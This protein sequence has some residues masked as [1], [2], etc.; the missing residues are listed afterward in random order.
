M[1][2]MFVDIL[3]KL[4]SEQGKEALLNPSKC[5][6]LLADYTK[7]DYKKESRL[8]LQAI[9]AGVQKVINTTGELELCKRQQA[10][11]LHE[12]YGIDQEISADIVD[13]LAF[14]LREKKECETPQSTF[15]TNCGKE[16]QKEW[17]V[18]PYCGTAVK[19]QQNSLKAEAPPLPSPVPAAQTAYPLPTA[20]EKKK[21]TVRNAALVIAGIILIIVLITVLS[22]EVSNSGQIAVPTTEN[23]NSK[24]A[25]QPG[26]GQHPNWKVATNTIGNHKIAFGNNRFVAGGYEGKAAY[27]SDGITWTAIENSIY[28]DRETDIDIYDITFGNNCF[29]AVGG[30][31]HRGMSRMAYSSDGIEWKAVANTTFGGN[32]VLAVTFG[33]NR[34]VAVGYGGRMAYSSDGATWTAVANRPFGN[35]ITTTIAFGN[36]RFVAG[37]WGKTA[38]SSDGVTWT[39]VPNSNLGDMSIYNMVYGNNRFVAALNYTGIIYSSDGIT[40]TRT[41]TSIFDVNHIRDIAFGNNI[42]VATGGDYGAA[43]SPD[44][45]TWTKSTIGDLP[46]FTI[47]FGN[48]RFIV[49]SNDKII[50]TE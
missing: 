34:F 7:G 21:H 41:A 49:T 3:Q 42:F 28:G 47:G 36:N 10:R 8:L 2:A 12:E 11:V 24:P 45:I 33:N 30:S 18:C 39:V 20:P 44:G 22:K 5:K 16:L 40:W 32:A 29:V 27:S 37:T 17:G 26:P 48:N 4:I 35:T 14:V 13:T 43:Y 31:N 46:F 9:D 50:Y 19:T 38:Y 25:P 1:N 15:C 23:S 6:A